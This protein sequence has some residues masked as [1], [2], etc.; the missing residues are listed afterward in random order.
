MGRFALTRGVRV[1]YVTRGGTSHATRRR[2][3]RTRTP[4]IPRISEDIDSIRMTPQRYA[5]RG[6]MVSQG[7]VG[8]KI[9]IPSGTLEE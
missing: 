6:D 5:A 7:L 2:N 3:T 4:Y 9:P 8:K 1:V